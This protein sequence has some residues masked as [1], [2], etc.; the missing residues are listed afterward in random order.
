MIVAGKVGVALLTAVALKRA[1]C[2][3]DI[4]RVLYYLPGDRLGRGGRRCCFRSVFDPQ[5]GLLNYYITDVLQW[6][7]PVWLGDASA[8]DP[9]DLGGHDLVDVRVPMLVFLAGLQNIP[10]SSV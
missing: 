2:G 4:F 6:P 1:F 10:E 8:G 7:A 5:R 9:L 3:R